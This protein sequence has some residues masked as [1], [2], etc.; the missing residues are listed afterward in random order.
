MVSFLVANAR[1]ILGGFALTY[2]SS[3]GQTFFIAGSAADWQVQ[4]GLSYGGFGQ[5]YMIATFASALSLPTVGKLVDVVSERTAIFISVPI[6]A[7]AMVLVSQANTVLLLGVSIYLL[8]LFGQGMMTHMALTAT[9]RW[10]AAQRGWAMSLVV[11]GHQGGEASLPLLAALITIAYGFEASWLFGAGALM[12]IALPLA[13]WAYAKPRVPRQAANAVRDAADAGDDMRQWRRKEVLRDPVFWLL[14]TGLLAPAFIG[15]TI[16]FHQDYLTA[17]RGWPPQLFATSM[18]VMAATTIACAL[19][20]GALIDRFSARAIL[21]FFLFPLAASCFIAAMLG[22]SV[23]LFVFM[24][25]LGVSY[26]FSSTLFGA[27]W[28]EIYG[29]RYLGEVRAG[30]VSAMVVATAIGPGLTGTLIDYGIA[31]PQQLLGM[32]AYCVA[33]AGLLWLASTKLK[34]REETQA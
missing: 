33:A 25:L 23:W 30:I 16:F 27:L 15:T 22:G 24:V 10:F 31:L 18:G 21:P 28:P 34:M 5:L 7:A 32:G 17:L 20:C 8:R 11:L 13:G 1:W 6:L 4:L 29:T 14:L 26:G 9:G 2:F 12:L 19:I 3:F